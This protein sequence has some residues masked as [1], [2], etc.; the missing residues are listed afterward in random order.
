MDC[1]CGQFQ[2][3]TRME[4]NKKSI[5]RKALWGFLIFS[6]ILLLSFLE[7]EVYLNS[8]PNVT[9]YK[10]P[11]MTFVVNWTNLTTDLKLYVWNS[12]GYEMINNYCYQESSNVSNSCG[13]LNTGNYQANYNT[14]YYGTLGNMIDGNWSS[15][16]ALGSEQGFMTNYTIPKGTNINQS[17]WQTKMGS[18]AGADI[19]Q[20]LTIGNNCSIVNNVLSLFSYEIASVGGRAMGIV[21]YCF[22]SDGWNN[23]SFLPLNPVYNGS[24][25][26][27]VDYNRVYE[28]AI[29]WNKGTNISEDI[30]NTTTFSYNFTNDGIY[31]W[32]ALGD[33][34]N[35]SNLGNFTFIID[36]KQPNINITFPVNNSA[37]ITPYINFSVQ[38]GDTNLQSCWYSNDSGTTNTSIASP[39]NN[40]TG[41][42]WGEGNNFVLVWVNDSAGNENYNSVNFTINTATPVIVINSPQSTESS[43]NFKVNITASASSGI[44]YCS[45]WITRGASLEV[46]NTSINL[47]TYTE[48]TIVSGE[49]NYNLHIYC[50]DTLGGETTTAKA[51]SVHFPSVSGGGASPSNPVLPNMTIETRQT[52]CLAFQNTFYDCLNVNENL[53]FF[54][55]INACYPS[56]LDFDIC[57]ASASIIPI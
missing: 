15:Y 4:K 35:W 19:L 13:G 16:D 43:I 10:N 21:F 27:I 24:G 23:L 25:N 39:C 33:S 30:T 7:A 8:P 6:G 31:L 11:N 41:I 22:S 37:Y 32:N 47:G 56:F 17:K 29:L 38:A 44:S 55:K 18:Y 48:N 42:K 26:S 46:A 14:S 12:S 2:E 1:F 20:N 52:I 28:E 34:S 5:V 57:K 3:E 36:T 9:Y 51:F 50:N 40:I 53:D 49:A 45:F 54:A